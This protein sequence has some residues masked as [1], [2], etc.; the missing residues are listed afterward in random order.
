MNGFVIFRQQLLQVFE[1]YDASRNSGERM[2]WKITTKSALTILMSIFVVG[3]NACAVLQPPD[4]NGPRS[5]LPPYPIIA[6]EPGLLQGATLSWQQLS[7][8][9]GLAQNTS[10]DL[11]GLTGTIHG[12]PNSSVGSIFLPKVGVE[13][14]HTEEEIRESLRR[15]I[16][17]WHG[18]IGAE[19]DQLS[20]VERVDNASGIKV[21]RYEQRPFRYPLRGEFGNLV[22]R[23]QADRR[24]VDISSTCLPKTDRLQAAIAALTP[25]VTVEN[26]VDLVKAHAITAKD[27]TGQ[28]RTL[29]LTDTNGLEARQLVAYAL[30]S[31]NQQSLELHLAWEIH[32]SNGPIK[33]IY[34]DAIT[35]QVIAIA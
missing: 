14:T 11:G 8:R 2:S 13:A 26:A 25:K 31:E 5:N 6:N 1:L 24:V 19:P 3:L 18:L 34:L 33:T 27:A 30:A 21:A 7:Q 12:V 23:F 15:F 9:Y 17:E 16:A 22:I 10:P 35:E 28:Q 29:T 20:L 4:A 32:V